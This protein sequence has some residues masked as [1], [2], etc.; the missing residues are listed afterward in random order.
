MMH[1]NNIFKMRLRE[2]NHTRKFLFSMGFFG[3][4]G[5]L[6]ATYL[7]IVH[8]KN[9]IPPCSAITNCE[10]VLTS[11]YAVLFGIPVALIGSLYYLLLLATLLL[12]LQEKRK[13]L[14]LLALL[15]TCVAMIISI[16]L[17]GIQAFVLHAFC[18]YCLLVE[19]INTVLFGIT[20]GLWRSYFT[21]SSA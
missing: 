14:L 2:N 13:T 15:F 5:F 11:K 21:S 6:D 18:Q 7:T 12:L 20:F 3:F 8:Y 19:A 16:L 17:V 9:L 10:L 4:L 1:L